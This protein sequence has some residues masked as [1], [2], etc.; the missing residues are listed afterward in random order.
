M[1]R[2]YTAQ[3]YDL[4]RVALAWDGMGRFCANV[5]LYICDRFALIPHAKR[6]IDVILGGRIFDKR[7][8]R[9]CEEDITPALNP[10]Q[11]VLLAVRAY[12]RI[13][14]NVSGLKTK[15]RKEQTQAV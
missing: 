6:S 9:T 11:C 5:S 14:I 7:T 1:N 4:V 10:L 3:T 13:H 2:T 12:S 8:A 15:R